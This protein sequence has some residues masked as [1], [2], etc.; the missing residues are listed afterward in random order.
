MCATKEK[1]T[2]FNER[3]KVAGPLRKELIIAAS[4]SRYVD[5][6]DLLT[7]AWEGFFGSLLLKNITRIVIS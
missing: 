4:L 1:I 5:N 7:V 3:K 6:M 2:F